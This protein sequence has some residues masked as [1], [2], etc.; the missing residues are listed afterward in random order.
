MYI[1]AETATI[2]FCND[3]FILYIHSAVFRKCLKGG[4]TEVP[5]MGGGG[6][7]RLHPTLQKV[8]CLICTT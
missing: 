4:K 1:G 6:G 3:A 2:S 7:V 5:K 8:K